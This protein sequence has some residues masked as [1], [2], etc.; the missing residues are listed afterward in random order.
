MAEDAARV[1]SKKARE[2]IFFTI[3]KLYNQQRPNFSK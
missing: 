1:K 2:G 3:V